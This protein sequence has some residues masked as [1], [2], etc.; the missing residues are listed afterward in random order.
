MKGLTSIDAQNRKK[1]GLS[2]QVIDSYIP[3]TPAILRRNF[4]NLINLTLLPVVIA[5]IY[6][7][8]EKEILAFGIFGIVNSIVSSMDEIRIKS[9]LQKL[10]SDFRLTANVVR[11][12]VLQC[13]PINEI[14]R[15]D[16]IKVKEGEGIY[17]D[18]SVVEARYALLDE[19]SLTGESEYIKKNKDDKVFSGSFLV[20]GEITYTAQNVGKGNYLNKIAT[21][22]TKFKRQKS[23]LEKDGINLTIFLVF[24]A[25]LAGLINLYATSQNPAEYRLL[26]LATIIALIIPQT[27]IFLFTLSFT[28]SVTKLANKG[29]LVQKGSSI[30]EIS[31]VDVVCV[32]KTGTITTNEMK[33]NEVKYFNTKASD[34]SDF[35]LSI[36]DHIVS[37]N[38]T[39]EVILK[40]YE[41]WTR[42]SEHNPKSN[43]HIQILK[44]QSSK[45]IT[46]TPFTSK[47]KF[48]SFKAQIEGSVVTLTL[49]ALSEL[50]KFIDKEVKSEVL[51]YVNT[52]EAL[53]N[54]V[55]VALY[56]KIPN[57]REQNP[58]I[59]NKLNNQ[60]SKHITVFSIHED[61]NPGIGEVIS[62]L[63]RQGISIKIISGDS[64]SSVSKIAEQIGIN[65][66]K[67]IEL[68]DKNRNYS[69]IIHNTIFTRATPD[70]KLELIKALKSKGH[71]V[72]MIGDGV[73]DV[74]AIKLA[75]V[76]IAMENGSK[77]TR[78]IADI[79]LL[80]NDYKK[81]P[82]I[83]F[84]ADNIIFNLKFSTKTFL[85]TAI[86]AIILSLIFSIYYQSPV[87]IFP[88]STL[89][90]S[91]LVSGL[92]SYIIVFTRQSIDSAKNFL[93]ECISSASISGI[94]LSIVCV[95]N[96]EFAKK[97]DYELIQINTLMVMSIL[98][99]GITY[100]TYLLHQA[101][102]LKSIHLSIFTGLLLLGVGI[103][104]TV[105]PI[106]QYK[107][108][109][110][111]VFLISVVGAG[112]LII[113]RFFTQLMDMSK[114]SKAIVMLVIFCTLPLIL[115]FPFD[116]YYTVERLP[117]TGYLFS[118]TVAFV[119]GMFMIIAKTLTRL[120]RS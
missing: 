22:S 39:L 43:A 36:K 64:Q 17:A 93:K 80:K 77:I 51:Q 75:D 33:I 72:A 113:A 10:K 21:Q 19:S 14:V 6:F 96:Y 13:I 15:G 95:I 62:S 61:L 78:E 38:K 79:V 29:I 74:L 56:S 11:D 112:L 86:F 54:R 49:G 16:L 65:S 34:I 42:V 71:K 116:D 26:S 44:T 82:E 45:L 23:N 60:N 2:N 30:D 63:G 50:E 5:L 32:D 66:S 41:H 40:H 118:V 76:G 105:L 1:L 9:K 27:L 4:F 94:F 59:A 35:L 31:N 18:G 70:D 102:K 110:E 47:N 92:P 104:Q 117:V 25:I 111:L 98:A 85:S 73:N 106:T 12:N 108:P 37:K 89:I 81:I 120:K 52:Q 87:P 114:Q 20:T 119:L 97:E 91:F 3:S 115:I 57:K 107:N 55:I 58:K 99:F 83:F 109:N 90:S 46:Q 24:S 100:T 103:V 69:E 8:L 101:K 88:S 48:S 7:D 68:N 53:G 28:I 84:E 67:I